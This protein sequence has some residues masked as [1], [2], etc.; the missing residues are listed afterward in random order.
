MG[1]LSKQGEPHVL[2]LASGQSF[3]RRGSNGS[4]NN[5]RSGVRSEQFNWFVEPPSHNLK[6]AW[7]SINKLLIDLA[8]NNNDDTK[9]DTT[10]VTGMGIPNKNKQYSEKDSNIY[11][12]D[13]VGLS[14]TAENETVATKIRDDLSESEKVNTFEKADSEEGQENLQVV[15]ENNLRV[16]KGRSVSHQYLIQK[17]CLSDREGRYKNSKGK[18][19]PNLSPDLRLIESFE[20]DS[21]EEEIVAP[22]SKKKP[23]GYKLTPQP[24]SKAK[25]RYQSNTF[26]TFEQDTYGKVMESEG[27]YTIT[28]KEGFVSSKKS[29]LDYGGSLMKKHA[30]QQA[31]HMSGNRD[32][33]GSNYVE[34][35]NRKI[36][37]S[38]AE[39]H[40]P[41]YIQKEMPQA[42]PEDDLEQDDFQLNM[43]DDEDGDY[44]YYQSQVVSSRNKI[45][46]PKDY[47]PQNSQPQ[48]VRQSNTSSDWHNKTNPLGG[49]LNDRASRETPEGIPKM[50]TSRSSNEL[51]YGKY[52]SREDDGY[53]DLNM[54]LSMPNKYQNQNKSTK[55]IP[56][57]IPGENQK[58]RRDLKKRSPLNA[59]KKTTPKTYQ[60]PNP[61]A[62]KIAMHKENLRK[63]RNASLTPPHS[64]PNLS[65]SGIERDTSCGAGGGQYYNN[66]I[67]KLANNMAGERIRKQISKDGTNFYS[68]NTKL[69]TL[70]EPNFDENYNTKRTIHKRQ[71]SRNS[72]Y[73]AENYS[74]EATGNMPPMRPNQVEDPNQAGNHGGGDSSER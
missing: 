17:E 30:S 6:I 50:P 28:K 44:N 48:V 10:A 29:E 64:K 9:S 5:S 63:I 71:K 39:E 18:F 62:G 7:L 38:H 12:R 23:S 45:A 36:Q 31:L 57:D 16:H 26:K 74:N 22:I 27:E 54:K 73:G 67:E 72:D 40:A 25:E 65:S 41:G 59:P 1:L 70:K 34:Y 21:D 37:K 2:G 15:R 52:S 61:N 4:N 66:K 55:Y 14:E 8:N 42:E 60:N 11:A 56:Q 46:D 20:D 47:Y 32:S 19:N 58:N 35:H 68:K 43:D 13:T 51:G 24:S 69:N 49:L 3:G 53:E 33:Y